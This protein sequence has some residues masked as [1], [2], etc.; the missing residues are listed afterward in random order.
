MRRIAM[1]SVGI[2]LVFLGGIWIFK[3]VYGESIAGTAEDIA[4][5]MVAAKIN[6]S[7]VTGFYDEKLDG[8]LLR[9]ERDK[10]GNIKY[11]QG[12]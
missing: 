12:S 1:I 10:D 8:T 4:V 9:V 2:V 5:N 7:L 6:E 11:K 3:D